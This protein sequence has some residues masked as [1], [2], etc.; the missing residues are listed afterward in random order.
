MSFQ[1]CTKA[2]NNASDMLNILPAAVFFRD[3]R[4]SRNLEGTLFSDSFCLTG[5]DF[6][7][8]IDFF[9]CLHKVLMQ[10]IQ[11]DFFGISTTSK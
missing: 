5:L 7:Y 6:E 11:L 10:Y 3:P 1:K 9:K 2:M 8:N 4:D